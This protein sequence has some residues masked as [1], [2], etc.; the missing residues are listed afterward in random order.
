MQAAERGR[1]LVAQ[2]LTFSRRSPEQRQL[3]ELAA[4]ISEVVQLLRGSYTQ[5][6]VL[7]LETRDCVVAGDATALHQLIMNLC[8][9]G[10]QAIAAN[11]IANPSYVGT[12]SIL[13]ADHYITADAPLINIETSRPLAPNHYAVLRVADDGVGMSPETRAHMFDPFFTTKAAGSGTGLGLSL[14]LSIAHA[15][16]GAITCET[17]LSSGTKFSVY[18]PISSYGYCQYSI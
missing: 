15:H 14:A 8:T 4:L 13:L 18:L 2:V 16:G 6:I 7:D 5:Q 9:N 10:L 3:V 12:L 17:S 11:N 1:L